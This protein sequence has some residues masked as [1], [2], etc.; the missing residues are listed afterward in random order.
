MDLGGLYAR[1]EV[2]EKDM[3]QGLAPF[4]NITSPRSRSGLE[5]RGTP[6]RCAEAWSRP[7]TKVRDH[8]LSEKAHPLNQ[9][10]E[11]ADSDALRELIGLGARTQD[12]H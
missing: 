8:A 1:G 6:A 11:G 12:N 9:A 2:V 3:N 4:A 10:I 7:G 5:P